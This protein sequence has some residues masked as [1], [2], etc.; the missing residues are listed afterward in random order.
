MGIKG[1]GILS[2]YLINSGRMSFSFFVFLGNKFRQI[3]I[4][5]RNTSPTSNRAVSRG[6]HVCPRAATSSPPYCLRVNQRVIAFADWVPL[7]L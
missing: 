2:I 3:K 7:R 5:G 6:F 1:L 4:V